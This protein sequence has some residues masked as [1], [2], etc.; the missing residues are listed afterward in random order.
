VVGIAR[1]LGAPVHL[2]GHSYGGALALRAALELGA[3][4]ASLALIEP[5]AFHLLRLEGDPAWSEIADVATR[6]IELVG[7]G[8]LEACADAFMGYWMGPAAWG[9]ATAAMRAKVV[10]AMPKVADEWRGVFVESHPPARYARIEAP[11]LLVRG[12][13]TTRAARRVVDLLAGALPD[14][15]LEEIRGAG[16]LSPVTHPAAVVKAIAGHLDRADVGA[17]IAA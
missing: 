17:R 1:S 16:H 5:V 6:H 10:A 4:V 7:A 15:A 2:V 12:T 11:T 3:G 13:R 14:C 9:A 8:E